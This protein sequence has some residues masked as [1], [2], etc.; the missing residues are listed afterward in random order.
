ML[1]RHR[2][3]ADALCRFVFK[4]ICLPQP[5]FSSLPLPSLASTEKVPSSGIRSFIDITVEQMASVHPPLGVSITLRARSLFLS[6][7]LSLTRSFTDFVCGLSRRS[8][9][10]F[11]FHS[12]S[13]RLYL[14]PSRSL[15]SHVLDDS[16]ELFG[17]HEREPPL[18]SSTT[19]LHTGTLRIPE[20]ER[21]LYSHSRLTCRIIRNSSAKT[22]IA[23]VSLANTG[24]KWK[25]N[26]FAI[27]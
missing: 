27:L 10:L 14:P 25:R 20:D 6:L 23:V 7:S 12:F 15:L 4:V 11:F 26:E 1:S 13:D 17:P 18:F 22:R 16:R 21:R 19:K 8:L 9:S 2:L 5:R 3:H 24:L